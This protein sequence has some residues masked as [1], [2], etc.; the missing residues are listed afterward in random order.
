MKKILLSGNG[1]EGI[2]AIK[3]TSRYNFDLATALP[4]PLEMTGMSVV[5]IEL[6]S[7]YNFTLAATLL[8]PLE[9]TGSNGIWNLTTG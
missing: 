9:V 3:I 8:K 7:R 6:T 4:K 2:I 1:K 5:E